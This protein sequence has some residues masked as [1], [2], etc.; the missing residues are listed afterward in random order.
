MRDDDK[1]AAF[2]N[3]PCTSASFSQTPLLK[4]KRRRAEPAASNRTHPLK[5]RARDRVAVADGAHHA[6]VDAVP[7]PRD[8]DKDLGLEGL[9]VGGY[10]GRLGGWR[11]GGWRYNTWSKLQQ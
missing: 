10:V 11:L 4:T 5:Q 8:A 1:T 7:E 3:A 6:V 9:A 2:L